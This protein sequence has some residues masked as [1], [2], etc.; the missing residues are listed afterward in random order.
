M[1]IADF[2][3]SKK[4]H[5]SKESMSANSTTNIKGTP[6]Y[7]APEIWSDQEYTPACD[8][9]SYAIIVFEIVTS[10]APWKNLSHIQI[11]N[12]VMSGFR[13]E[14]KSYV[15]ESYKNLIEKC[16]DQEPKNGQHL[17]KY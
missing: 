9:Y 4:K 13:P 14:I 12:K 6:L 11:I 3:L 17:T 5:Q 2:G 7:I 10:E 8:V 16:W 15:P 1:S